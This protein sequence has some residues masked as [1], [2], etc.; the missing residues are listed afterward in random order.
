M[1]Y[2]DL[3]LHEPGDDLIKRSLGPRLNL[4]SRLILNRVGN[5]DGVKVRA[6]QSGCLSARGRHEFTRSD[7]HCRDA[8]AFEF[9]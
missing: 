8:E 2:F 6:A 4:L 7:R 1:F 3:R 5:V 9:C